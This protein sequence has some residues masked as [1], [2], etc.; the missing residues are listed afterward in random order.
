MV[1]V[2]IMLNLLIALMADA[3]GRVQAMARPEFLKERARILVEIMTEADE[4]RLALG[5]AVTF[6]ISQTDRDNVAD[7]ATRLQQDEVTMRLRTLEQGLTDER[8]RSAA[9]ARRLYASI[10]S[11]ERA[12]VKQAKGAKKRK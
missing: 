1:V 3:Y 9:Q 10:G 4:H 12:I 11:I 6:Q 8:D 7:A 2:I 5:D